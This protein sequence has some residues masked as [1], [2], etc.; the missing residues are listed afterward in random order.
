[1]FIPSKHKEMF[2]PN[3]GHIPTAINIQWQK[4]LNPDGTYKSADELQDLYQR[5]GVHR[6]EEVMVY[7]SVGERSGQ[8]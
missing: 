4:A 8:T 1:M 5:S 6:D 3:K 7:C 2:H